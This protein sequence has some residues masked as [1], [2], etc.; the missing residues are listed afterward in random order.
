ML[1]IVAHYI[2]LQLKSLAWRLSRPVLDFPEYLLSDRVKPYSL[3]WVG[4]G[5]YIVAGIR[6]TVRNR[7]A[8]SIA[9]DSTIFEWRVKGVSKLIFPRGRI[10][11]RD[12]TTF[13]EERSNSTF[14]E[15]GDLSSTPEC[16]STSR[17]QIVTTEITTVA[18]ALRRQ[19][20]QL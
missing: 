5:F 13:E 17:H 4:L 14:Q 15:Q 18:G 8:G 20:I 1:V 2:R 11:T 7:P 6:A 3:I 12:Q 16:A 19:H 9:R 10:N